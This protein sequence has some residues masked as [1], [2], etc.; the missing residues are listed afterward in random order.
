MSSGI[1]FDIKE[2]A[3]FDG[4]GI[5][6]TIFFKGCPLRCHWCHNPEGFSFQ[7][8]LMVSPMGCTHCGKCEAVCVCQAKP[9]PLPS[10][11]CTVCG[12][13]I[14]I[15]PMGLRRISGTEYTAEDLAKR[16]LRD[17]AYLES[18][19]GG[20]TISGGEPTGQGEFL[21]ELLERLRGSHRAIETSGFCTAELFSAVLEELELALIDIK[22]M[23]RENH[24]NFTGGDNTGILENVEILKRSLRPHIVRIPVIPAVN[25]NEENFRAVADF[26]SDDKA[27]LRVELLPYHRTAGAKY[28]MLNMEYR[29]E[30]D[31]EQAPN[32]NTG[33]FLS[34]NIP[35]FVV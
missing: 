22:L 14:P 30:F 7:P 32:L 29:P 31:V 11:D 13:C 4:P 3:V 35:C 8:Q 34:R 27:L 26:L 2:F 33:I 15:C 12:G 24:L 6:T 19:G 10:H 23:D 16:L 17:A 28:N 1:I 20:Y 18:N 25:D 5:R 9:S 21:V